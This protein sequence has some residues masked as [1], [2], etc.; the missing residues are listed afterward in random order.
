VLRRA[1]RPRGGDGSGPRRRDVVEALLEALV[2]HDVLHLVEGD[3]LV[4]SPPWQPLCRPDVLPVPRDAL[5]L[6]VVRARLR[7]HALT[8]GGWTDDE[9]D[10]VAVARGV[11]WDPSTDLAVHLRR[12]AAEQVP[13]VAAVLV[14]GGRYLELGCGVGGSLLATMRTFPGL[15]AAGVELS[16]ELAAIARRS[17]ADLGLAARVEIVVGDAAEFDG[18][19]AFDVCFWS[20]FFFPTASR[21]PALVAARRSLRPG[22]V[23]VAPAPDLRLPPGPPFDDDARDVGNERVLWATWGVPVRTPDELVTEA[24]TVGF[25]DARVLEG[26]HVPSLVGRAPA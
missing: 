9:S 17:A 24:L 4:V 6:G 16:P 23:L 19:G 15:T 20:Q 14:P 2:L 11:R 26:A 13:E 25:D 5:E 22:G 10:L 18:Q 8:D 12:R 3:R 1:D 21:L 7:R